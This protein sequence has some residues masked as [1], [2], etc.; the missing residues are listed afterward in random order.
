MIRLKQGIFLCQPQTDQS[1][2]AQQAETTV[3][4]SNDLFSEHLVGRCDLTRSSFVRLS[5]GRVVPC[6]VLSSLCV[7]VLEW[8]VLEMSGRGRL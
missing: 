2:I 5:S 3:L 1:S 7:S 8:D 4:T 6:A